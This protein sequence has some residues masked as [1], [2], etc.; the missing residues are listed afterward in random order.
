MNYEII[1][2]CKKNQNLVGKEIYYMLD[3]GVTEGVLLSEALE[4]IYEA[5]KNNLWRAVNGD[6]SEDDPRS[7]NYRPFGL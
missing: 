5:S 1:N 6:F 7:D 3:N 2:F 4:A